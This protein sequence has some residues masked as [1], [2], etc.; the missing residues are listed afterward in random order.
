MISVTRNFTIRHQRF[1]LFSLPCLKGQ[2][3]YMT[4]SK[5]DTL[6]SLI[7]TDTS[8]MSKPVNRR[9]INVNPFTF[10]RVAIHHDRYGDYS[11]SSLA[12]V[13]QEVYQTTKNKTRD[14]IARGR[15]YF[16]S[17]HHFAQRAPATIMLP[18]IRS[19]VPSNYSFARRRGFQSIL[20]DA[21]CLL[22]C[23]ILWEQYDLTIS[24]LRP[25]TI[26]IFMAL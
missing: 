1:I 4:L 16:E 17:Q 21:I 26:A 23:Y 11:I 2:I 7:I 18:S 24:A 13:F 6:K 5:K 12:R 15:R 22:C 20:L 9:K 25:S 10:T 19:L 8:T 3:M 14:Y